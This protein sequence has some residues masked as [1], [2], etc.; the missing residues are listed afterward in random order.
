MPFYKRNLIVLWIGCFATG[1]GMSMIVPF[2]PLFIDTLS[3][4]TRQELAFWSGIIA[5]APFLM[6]ALI[7]PLWGR[8]AD[9]YGQKPMLLRAS[10]GMSI[11]ISATGFVTSIWAFLAL[12]AV[13]G[14]LSGYL[15]NAIALIAVQTPKEES[16]RVLGT[17]NTANVGG[18]L[19]GPL[20]G[21]FVVTF[22]GYAQ[23]FFTTG[24]IIG[25][26]F[27]LTLFLIKEDFTPVS[28][29]QEVSIKTAFRIIDNPQLILGMFLTTL[30][31]MLANSA[32]NPILS[33]YVRDIL[34][35]GES[36]ELWSG[37]VAAAPGVTTIF[38]A[39]R[40][41]ALG[42]RIG[43]QKV[44]LFGLGFSALIFIPM[45][46][47]TSIW[48]FTALRLLI[49]VGNAALTPCVQ[50]LLSRNTP[51]EAIGR[52]FA[53]NQSSQSIGLVV[54]PLLGASIAGMLAF[55]Y[56]FFATTLLLLIN[57][58]IVLRV[59]RTKPGDQQSESTPEN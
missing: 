36:V 24:G 37:I 21:A 10:L 4:F 48:L 54:G 26:A 27:F 52:I 2:I 49:G 43:T 34:P 50:A 28:K 30:I 53:L 17:M 9:R 32:I 19:V 35:E 25:A 45:G 44:L 13:F 58:L 55:P 29:G 33:L 8:L 31:I 46:L 38:A 22:A 14:I 39:P 41:G 3:D 5:S 57:L 12:R 16:G 51:K 40:L 47:I 56:I 15:V 23:I 1:V 11:I 6:Q 20:L 42:D 18:M 7:A 59:S